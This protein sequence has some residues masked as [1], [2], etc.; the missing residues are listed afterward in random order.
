M[1]LME[2]LLGI[3]IMKTFASLFNSEKCD[4]WPYELIFYCCIP[5]TISSSYI[6]C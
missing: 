5:C 4:F 3:N 2:K 6:M 1:K